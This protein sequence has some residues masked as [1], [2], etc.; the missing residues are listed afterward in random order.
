VEGVI[1]DRKKKKGLLL[2][3]K[4]KISDTKKKLIKG[5]QLLDTRLKL[6]N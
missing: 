4:K 1:T 6:E 5:G 2:K 3:I